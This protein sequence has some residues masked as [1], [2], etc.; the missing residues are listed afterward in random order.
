MSKTKMRVRELAGWGL[1]QNQYRPATYRG[2]VD[3]AESF[4]KRRA[5]L[6]D[7]TPLIGDC[8]LR[9]YLSA[10]ASR[11]DLRTE[12]TGLDWFLDVVDVRLLLAF[13]RRIILNPAVQDSPQP[14]PDDWDGLIKLC[15]GEPKRV[16]CEAIRNDAS[17][18]IRSTNPNLQ[19]R[20]T[21]DNTSPIAVHSGSPFL[22]VAQYRDRWFLRDGYHRAFRCLQTGV[23]HLPAVVVRA[24]TLEELGAVH[25]WFF[26]E[27]VLFSSSAPRV[28]DF[29]DDALVIEYNRSL[30]IKTLR[31]TVEE[32]YS[33]QG[34]E[35]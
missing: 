14:A 5:L 24:R 28:I 27:E 1:D 10:Q 4:I 13:Q 9:E 15:F 7:K 21:D 19:F 34:D 18:L 20:I 17:V 6:E 25:P 11:A 23:F 30:L 26:S 8:R 22:E 31:I 16:V 3:C 12:M 2:S 35:S 29:L 33:I 32:T